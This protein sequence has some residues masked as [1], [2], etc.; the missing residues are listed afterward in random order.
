MSFSHTSQG[1]EHPDWSS[2]RWKY[3]AVLWD[4]DDLVTAQLRDLV[5]AVA[6]LGQNLVGMLTE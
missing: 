1:H 6:Q 4:S 5:F 2:E 3:Q